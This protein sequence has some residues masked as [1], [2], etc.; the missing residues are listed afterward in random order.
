M[1]QVVHPG[2]GFFPPRIQGV[3][4]APDPGSATLMVTWKDQTTES[5]VPL[6]V[7][8]SLW[9]PLFQPEKPK[10]VYVT[11]FSA[12]ASVWGS[13]LSSFWADEAVLVT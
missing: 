8:K 12:S 11:M 2:S 4:K 7:R 3:I 10:P 13:L 6:V 1:I 5:N 9:R